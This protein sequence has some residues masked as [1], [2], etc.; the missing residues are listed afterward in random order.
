MVSV[1]SW[2]VANKT[3]VHRRVAIWRKPKREV[4]LH[5]EGVIVSWTGVGD[6]EESCVVGVRVAFNGCSFVARITTRNLQRRNKIQ[7]QL[8]TIKQAAYW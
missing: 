7:V 1:I 5:D 8:W 6:V 4:R 3:A 2:P